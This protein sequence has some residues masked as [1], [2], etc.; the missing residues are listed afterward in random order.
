M[1]LNHLLI[2]SIIQGF[3]EFLPISSS[4]HLIIIPKIMSWPDQGLVFDVAVHVGTLGAVI[5]Y[6]HRDLFNILIGLI[7]LC[8]GKKDPR[9][10]LLV[11]IIISTLPIVFVGYFFVEYVENY[12]RSAELIGWVTILFGI[13][14]YLIDKFS[15]RVKKIVHLDYKDSLVVGFFQAMALIPGVSRSGV[16]ITILRFLGYEREDA[17]FFSMLL[18]IPTISL[19]GIWLFQKLYKMEDVSFNNDIFLATIVSFITALISITFL[20][21]WVRRSNFTVFVIYRLILGFII[22]SFSYLGM[23]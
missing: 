21:R 2:L 7:K 20:M 5:I 10:R 8:L 4:S 12:F 16:S 14:L 3:T 1:I 22:L 18:S 9:A 23:L 13:F 17:T 11:N 15:L 19:S 6:F